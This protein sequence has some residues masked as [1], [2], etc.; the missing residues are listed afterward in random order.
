MSAR[1]ERAT[2]TL[3]AQAFEAL[4][5]VTGLYLAASPWV[6]GFSGMTAL[7]ISNLVVG[8]AYTFCIMGFATAY[9]RTHARSWAAAALGAWMII[10]PWVVVGGF[11]TTRTILSNVIGGAV[12]LVVAL[13]ISAMP[14]VTRWRQA[15]ASY[16]SSGG[17]G[18]PG[19]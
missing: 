2:A 8:L 3:P 13:A 15:M 4:A 19:G 5:I 11:D 6:V 17:S 14:A 12:A 16:G 9:E 10:A 7:A 1:Y 18:M